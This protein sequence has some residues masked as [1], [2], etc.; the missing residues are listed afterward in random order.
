M[1]NSVS[2]PMAGSS[3][4]CSSEP[5]LGSG[6]YEISECQYLPAS[7]RPTGAPFSTMLDTTRISGLCARWN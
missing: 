4:A 5:R 1:A 2:P 7:P 3:C 6:L